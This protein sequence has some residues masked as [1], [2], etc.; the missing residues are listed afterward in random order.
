MW[1]TPLCRMDFPVWAERRWTGSQERTWAYFELQAVLLRRAS[2]WVW[3]MTSRGR[4]FTT[5][6]FLC[7]LEPAVTSEACHIEAKMGLDFSPSHRQQTINDIKS[8]SHN[9][10][11]STSSAHSLFQIFIALFQTMKTEHAYHHTSK[12]T[13]PLMTH[14]QGWTT[15]NLISA[16]LY[17]EP[18]ESIFV[19]II[20]K[21][22]LVD[23]V[24]WLAISKVQS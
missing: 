7:P 24:L 13:P 20:K 9:L 3:F 14:S 17:V 16:I 15:P 21:K 6:G 1:T 12:G 8:D 2:L 10:N 19:I 5:D 22:S 11:G 4:H 23:F 18:L